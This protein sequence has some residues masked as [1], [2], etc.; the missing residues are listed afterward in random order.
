V[1]EEA[2][3]EPRTLADVLLTL[4]TR[5]KADGLQAI[6]YRGA[7]SSREAMLEGFFHPFPN[8]KGVPKPK[9]WLFCRNV[10][11]PH[12]QPHTT[13]PNLRKTVVTLAHETGHFLSWRLASSGATA[14]WHAYF[15]AACQ[16][17]EDP[18]K[19][20]AEQKHLI[21]AEEE[22]AWDLGRPLLIDA[23]FGEWSAFDEARDTGLRNHRILMGLE[24][25]K[26]QP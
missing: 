10:P 1:P 21:M 3:G 12:D 24:P 13:D 16:R 25:E 2:T 17:D 5:A 11:H 18:T 26:T 6:L 14:A 9:I 7:L 4:W 19:L 22:R 20:A 8:R 15:A 23:G